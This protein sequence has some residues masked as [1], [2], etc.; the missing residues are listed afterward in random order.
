MM[1]NRIKCLNIPKPTVLGAVIYQIRAQCV[2]V[3]KGKAENTELSKSNGMDG[4]KMFRPIVIS[5]A[6]KR[7]CYF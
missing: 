4:E 6:R 5:I 7:G 1:S 2:N 3:L